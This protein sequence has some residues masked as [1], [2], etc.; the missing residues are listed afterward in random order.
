MNEVTQLISTIKRQLKAQGLTYRDV[1][2]SLELSEVSVK[3]MFASERMSLDRLAQLSALLGFTLTELAQEAAN[4]TPKLHA[5]SHKQEA[6]LVADPK[7]LL[8]AVCVLNHW[9][10][11]QIV[12]AYHI[13]YVEC[14]KK[15]LML[16]R[17]NMI[18]LL[19]GD[20]V[21]VTVMR[22]FRW[23]PGGPIQSFFRQEGLHD[24]FDDTFQGS[25]QIM[26]FSHAMLTEP[27][28]EQLQAELRRLR[29]RIASLHEESA[30]A[31]IELRRGIGMLMAAREWEPSIFARMRINAKE[32]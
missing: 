25:D 9:T 2:A 17:M 15:L 32:R 11:A 22:D 16:E 6:K 5:L 27:A 10:A 30:R 23:L 21:R 24:F 20:R 18:V 14:L 29:A 26:E 7:L 8:V 31:P 19:P 4:E 3:R 1:A 28:L 13:T 12:A